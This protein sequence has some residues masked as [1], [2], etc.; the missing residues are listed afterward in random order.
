MSKG[1]VLNAKTVSKLKREGL[2]LKRRLQVRSTNSSGIPGVTRYEYGNRV[3]W[4]AYW[5]EKGRKRSKKFSV[6]IHGEE[7]AKRRAVAC[8]QE[9]TRDQKKRLREIGQMLKDGAK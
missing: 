9:A 8:R 3:F 6:A 2:A 4:T 7:G 1:K 5:D